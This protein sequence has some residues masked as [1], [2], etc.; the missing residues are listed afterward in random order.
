M[1]GTKY[2]AT[3]KQQQLL[4]ENF[5]YSILNSPTFLNGQ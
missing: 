1:K 4:S 2:M 3:A 5:H